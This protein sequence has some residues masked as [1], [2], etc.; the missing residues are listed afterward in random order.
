MSPRHR[1]GRYSARHARAKGGRLSTWQIIRA[2]VDVQ[3][4]GRRYSDDDRVVF[5]IQR[6]LT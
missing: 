4:N 5:A 1:R 3:V 2:A 6:S